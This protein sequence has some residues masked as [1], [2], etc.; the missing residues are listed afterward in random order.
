MFEKEVKYRTSQDDLLSGMREFKRFQN[1]QLQLDLDNINILFSQACHKHGC[2][3][4]NIL[5]FLQDSALILENYNIGDK[6]CLPIAEVLKKLGHLKC[7]YRRNNKVTDTGISALLESLVYASLEKI[8]YQGNAFGVKA[9]ESLAKF[10]TQQNE[11]LDLNLDTAAI[12]LEAVV[13]LF[14]HCLTK[15]H[16]KI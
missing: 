1:N 14:T 9:V 15:Y 2:Y 7:L 8:V 5:K 11:L 10:F 13:Q 16:C 12:S 3:P 4:L 6:L